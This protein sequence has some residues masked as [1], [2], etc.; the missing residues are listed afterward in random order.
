MAKRAFQASFF[1]SVCESVSGPF[2]VLIM[3]VTKNRKTNAPA[4]T[5]AEI[6]CAT[7]TSAFSYEE[8]CEKHL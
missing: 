6:Y 5:T 7:C 4:V 3:S 8:K 2:R 1:Q